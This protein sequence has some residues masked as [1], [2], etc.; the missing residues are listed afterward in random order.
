MN[1]SV[2]RADMNTATSGQAVITKVIGG[3]GISLSSTGMDSGTGDVTVSSANVSGFVSKT[4]AYTLV[5][6]DSGKYF[7]CSGG[8]WTLTL[9]APATGLFF[10]IRN[11]QGITGTTGTITLTPSSGT[12][13]G[14]AS[15]TLLAGQE[16]LIMTDGTNW[17]TFGRQR[18]AVIGTRDIT[19]ST[20]SDS[21]LLPPGYRYYEL[22]WDN[23]LQTGTTSTGFFGARLSTNGGT[24]WIT[25]TSY[26]RGT[27]NS[28]NATTPGYGSTVS[29]NW[30]ALTDN[31][32]EGAGP[33]CG[34]VF[35]R[36]SPGNATVG[37]SWVVN[38][39]VYN[40]SAGYVS[41]WAN[42]GFYNVAGAVNA[43]QYYPSANAI[44]NSQLTVK[45][46]V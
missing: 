30:I 26:A 8:S 34:K 43:L 27:F 21:I 39:G 31:L 14:L 33:S 11:D 29:E 15:L 16:C 22:E 19:V 41:T 36:L 38:S 4:A 9:P 10:Q 40:G 35:M 24:S 32:P 17:R 3:T 42:F 6:A 23:V 20:A 25:A 37:P 46:V 18:T 7:I 28:S 2:Q 5:T 12:I 13:D 1:G 45:G 44:L